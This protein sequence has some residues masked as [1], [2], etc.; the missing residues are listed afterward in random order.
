MPGF[1]RVTRWVTGVMGWRGR[2]GYAG[3]EPVAVAG[4]LLRRVIGAGPLQQFEL[5][6]APVVPDRR[7]DLHVLPCRLGDGTRLYEVADGPVRK[8][9]NLGG[10][11]NAATNLRFR[12]TYEH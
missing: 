2:Q 6:I 10:D 3:G 4:T 1:F 11:P 9:Q 7:G 12:A 8:P 5:H